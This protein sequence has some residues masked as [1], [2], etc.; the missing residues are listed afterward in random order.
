MVSIRAATVFFSLFRMA[1]L[2]H[3]A[4]K[5]IP[6]T[7]GK[8]AQLFLMLNSP[9]IDVVVPTGFDSKF[10]DDHIILHISYLSINFLI[11]LPPPLHSSSELDAYNRK[12]MMRAT[13]SLPVAST[14]RGLSGQRCSLKVENTIGPEGLRNSR[15]SACRYFRKPEFGDGPCG[16]LYYFYD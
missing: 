8:C 3:T 13:V 7:R 15:L 10:N 5:Y 14:A 11:S 2:K 12:G 16:V 4:A 9:K 1:P 6:N